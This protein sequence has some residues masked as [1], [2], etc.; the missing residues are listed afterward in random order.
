M[1]QGGFG[2]AGAGNRSGRHI[3]TRGG[4]STTARERSR[5]ALHG[6]AIADGLKTPTRGELTEAIRVGRCWWCGADRGVDGR[7]FKSIAA[8][9]RF[10]HG[11]GAQV[12]R[13]ILGLPKHASFIVDELKA[14]LSLEGKR[15]YDPC[16]LRGKSGVRHELS[17]F[18]LSS[19]RQK[20]AV[21]QQRMS[22]MLNN[23]VEFR[24][25][26]GAAVSRGQGRV[27]VTELT[28]AICGR[29]FS[30]RTCDAS[31]YKN[32]SPECR[33]ESKRR[34]MKGRA[35][36]LETRRRISL[37]H[38][39]GDV[40]KECVVCRDVFVVSRKRSGRLTCGRKG[41]VNVARARARAVSRHAGCSA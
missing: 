20:I 25:R 23:D 39:K 13:D 15:R 4:L 1:I 19:Q 12:A 33:S 36:T 8:H 7:T 6:C 10:A 41:C 30:V 27:K 24:E 28:C 38:S 16:V 31:K 32:C 3:M 29:A 11:I 34:R 26:F 2:S 9:W 14:R 5:R 37:S 40:T 21:A 22:H 35:T 17:A 18:G